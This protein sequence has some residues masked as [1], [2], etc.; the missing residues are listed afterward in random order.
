VIAFDT[1]LTSD[2]SSGSLSSLLSIYLGL[3]NHRLLR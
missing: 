3:S 1:A 2:W